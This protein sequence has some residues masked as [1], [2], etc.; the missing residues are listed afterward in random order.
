M[1]GQAPYVVCLLRQVHGTRPRPRA[2]HAGAVNDARSAQI[3]GR[4]VNRE[5]ALR[6]RRAG[7]LIQAQVHAADGNARYCSVDPAAAARSARLLAA[8]T[9][10][11]HFSGDAAGGVVFLC[12]ERGL[13]AG[14][15]FAFLE[16]CRR[17]YEQALREALPLKSFLKRF[18]GELI[19]LRSAAEA[20]G[21][22]GAGLEQIEGKLQI[23]QVMKES[24][25]KVL[26]R[27]ERIE[28]LIDR[29]DHL[30]QR[31]PLRAGLDGARARS[32]GVAALLS[33]AGGVPASRRAAH[34]GRLRLV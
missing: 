7:H 22:D 9:A 34:P 21:G 11:F 13:G 23:K 10:T 26:D 1:R 30:Q 25:E 5:P 14:P 4:V 2:R 29:T 31:L 33:D 17:Q 27:G 8:V 3:D 15:A 24:V 32:A 6:R 19:E 18:E 12:A 28:L 20:D 16:R